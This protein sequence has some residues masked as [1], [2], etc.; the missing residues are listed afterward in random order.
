MHRGWMFHPSFKPEPF[1]AGCREKDTL[2]AIVKY[3][4]C[5]DALA[6]GAKASGI[7][8]LISKQLGIAK[9]K[10]LFKHDSRSMKEVVEDIYNAGRSR[11]IHGTNDKLGHD[12]STTQTQAEILARHCLVMCL[13]E[14]AVD[15]SM[16]DPKKFS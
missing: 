14:V 3:A 12:W 7:Q 15:P 9:G 13:G 10:S 2:I 4:A 8:M 1:Y 16:T 5:L 6:C 11:T